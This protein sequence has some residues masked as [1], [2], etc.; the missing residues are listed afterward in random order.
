MHAQPPQL[1]LVVPLV[2][3]IDPV[4]GPVYRVRLINISI[5]QPDQN[6]RVLTVRQRDHPVT[7]QL[8][9]S[10]LQRDQVH[11]VQD[12]ILL[13]ALALHVPPPNFNLPVLASGQNFLKILL[14][15]HRRDGLVVGL[16]CL[17]VLIPIQLPEVEVAREH[18][19]H[20]LALADP[21]AERRLLRVLPHTF[22]H[23]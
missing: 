9:E 2:D 18:P 8:R 6:V 3:Q 23:F 22:R 7:H 19:G 16:N 1:V 12:L 15:V 20:N 4:V 5:P 13:L 11:E 17:L 14:R 10:L 21:D